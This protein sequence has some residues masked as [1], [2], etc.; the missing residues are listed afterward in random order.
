MTAAEYK[1]IAHEA[2]QEAMQM[3]TKWHLD[4]RV[5]LA[6]IFALLVQTSGAF[7]WASNIDS[8][9]AELEKDYSESI[10]LSERVVRLEEQMKITNTLL[11][12]IRD[13]L[14][15]NK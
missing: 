8:R 7:W 5:P 9:V 13:T 10:V 6:L 11:Q 12:E 15:N 1:Q 3:E 2:V 4:K 14:K